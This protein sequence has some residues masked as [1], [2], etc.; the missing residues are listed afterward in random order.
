[1]NQV[2]LSGSDTLNINDRVFADL[3]DGDFTTLTFPEGIANAKTGK[4]GNSIFSFNAAGKRCEVIIRLIRGSAD[5]RY[6]NGLLAIQDNNFAATVL[7]AGEFIK[8]IGDG[9]GAIANDTYIMSGGIFTKRVEAKSNA[10]GDSE[11]SVAVYTLEFTNAPRVI[12]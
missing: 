8:K 5:D 3:A 10:E 4:N 2:A 12:A 7:M 9:K 1:M 11:Q 6:L